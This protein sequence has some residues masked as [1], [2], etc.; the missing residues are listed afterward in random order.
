MPTQKFPN[1]VKQKGTYVAAAAPAAAYV[2]VQDTFDIALGMRGFTEAVTDDSL[3]VGDRVGLLIKIDDENYKVA[4]GEITDLDG[5]IEIVEEELSVGTVTP[6]VELDVTISTTALSIER[7]LTTPKVFGPYDVEEFEVTD[8][9][10]GGIVLIESALP[11]VVTFN[12][13]SL[14]YTQCLI[15][16][17]GTGTVTVGTDA[18]EI[19]G[20]YKSAFALVSGYSGQ[21]EYIVV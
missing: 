7:A 18:L 3:E 12:I 14:V 11:C 17:L 20:Q 8:I 19:A 15:I 1:R 9:H 10:S 5:I 2:N 13:T 6:G 16:N 4:F 21:P